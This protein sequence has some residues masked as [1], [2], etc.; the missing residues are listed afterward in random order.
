M[1]CLSLG[2][3]LKHLW[4]TINVLQ[5]IIF[6][7][8]WLIT[9]PKNAEVFLTSLK[10]LALMEFMDDV[11]HWIMEQFGLREPVEDQGCGPKVE[12]EKK[13][14]WDEAGVLIFLG[15]LAL[16]IIMLVVAI[17]KCNSMITNDYRVYK[18]MMQTKQK[19]FWNFF[20]RYIYT[21][22]LKLQFFAFTIL[23]VK[24]AYDNERGKFEI[25]IAG[26]VLLHCAYIRFFTWVRAGRIE[27][28]LDIHS[29][30]VKINSL[31]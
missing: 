27:D 22:C 28:R 10:M 16:V 20:I 29:T 7:I 18:F 11:T 17:F 26:L 6:M 9:V 24:G 2:Y 4:N 15:L 5:F 8:S 3:G 19:I 25:A 12:I 31:Y 14:V 1:I 13:N 30:R 21:S 23:T